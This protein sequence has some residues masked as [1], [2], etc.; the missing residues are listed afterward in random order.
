MEDSVCALAMT[1][2]VASVPGHVACIALHVDQKSLLTLARVTRTRRTRT[3]ILLVSDNGL[4]EE[5]WAHE[6]LIDEPDAP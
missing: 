2:F 4:M 3:I 5:I 1:P 6:R